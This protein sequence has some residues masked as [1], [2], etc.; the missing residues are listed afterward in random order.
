MLFEDIRTSKPSFAKDPCVIRLGTR[1]YLYYTAHDGET[2]LY[3]VGIAASDDLTIM[4]DD[5]SNGHKGFVTDALRERLS[6][7]KTYD[8]VIAIGP[9]PMMKAVC[10]MTRPYGYKPLD[11]LKTGLKDG[12]AI[13]GSSGIRL[14]GRPRHVRVLPAYGE[15][16]DPLRLRG[17]PG[18]R[19]P[20]GGF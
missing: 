6:A 11:K 14:T 1:Y 10:E 4:T 17:R 13:S 7:G 16:R 20:S 8:E 5:G 19:R 3:G 18:I 2:D 12:T 9:I 15:R